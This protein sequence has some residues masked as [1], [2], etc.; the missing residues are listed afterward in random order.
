[1]TH[2]VSKLSSNLQRCLFRSYFSHSDGMAYSYLRIPI[3]GSDF[4][5]TPWAYN[6]YPENDAKL[7]NFTKLDPRDLERNAQLKDLK[8][9]AKNP[10]IKLLAAAWGPPKWMKFNNEWKG[11]EDSQLKPKYYQTWAEYHLKWLRLMDKDGLQIWAMSTGNEPKSAIQIPFQSVYWTPENQAKWIAENLGPMIKNSS[12]SH[13]E[14]H[15]LDENRDLAPAF[16]DGMAKTD[17]RSL[18][19]LTGLEFHAY[20]DKSLEPT[21]LDQFQDRFPNKYFNFP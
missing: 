14:L 21:I 13:V 4:D 8:S 9:I 10:S 3:G 18:N 1:M 12:Y 2:V 5:F 20:S 16:I 11:G 19:Y 7:S 6:E 17:E 15:G